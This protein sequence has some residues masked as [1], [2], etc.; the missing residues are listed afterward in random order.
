MTGLCP[1]FYS[2]NDPENTLNYTVLCSSIVCVWTSDSGITRSF[3]WSR[4]EPLVSSLSGSCIYSEKLNWTKQVIQS[5]NVFH[6]TSV[7]FISL[8]FHLFAASVLSLVRFLGRAASSGWFFCSLVNN[9]SSFE[10]LVEKSFNGIKIQSV[11][12]CKCCYRYIYRHF[13]Y[14]FSSMKQ[15]F[16][17]VDLVK[18]LYLMCMCTS[19]IW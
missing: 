13:F 12:W 16:I 8:L 6:S 3:V 11:F 17:S 19:L 9:W 10:C 7:A 1:C 5:Q 4:A 2:L 14:T 18:S 15:S